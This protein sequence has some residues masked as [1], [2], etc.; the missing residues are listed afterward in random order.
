[1][2][3]RRRETS[4]GLPGYACIYFYRTNGKTMGAGGAR[5]E[6]PEYYYCQG[7]SGISQS[8]VSTMLKYLSKTGLQ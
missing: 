8:T 1:M 5:K 6:A 2:N 4:N 7:G 3:S